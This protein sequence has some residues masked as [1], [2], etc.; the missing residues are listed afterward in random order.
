MSTTNLFDGSAKDG[1]SMSVAST[2]QAASA[3]SLQHQTPSLENLL[4]RSRLTSESTAAANELVEM[5]MKEGEQSVVDIDNEETE[6]GGSSISE[7]MDVEFMNQL[8]NSRDFFGLMDAYSMV[9]GESSDSA[10][11]TE[12]S[13]DIERAALRNYFSS[14]IL[15]ELALAENDMNEE[16]GSN[17]VEEGAT[18][19]A[20][21][22]RNSGASSATSGRSQSGNATG[23]G[24]RSKLGNYAEI[25]RNMMQ[26]MMDTGGGF[27]GEEIDIQLQEEM[28]DEEM[29]DDGNENE[30][31]EDD[32][33]TA[34]TA[35]S[36]LN[37]TV[38][39]SST[40]HSQVESLASAAAALRRQFSSGSS[41][42]GSSSQPGASSSQPS[43]FTTAGSEKMN[44]R[45]IVMN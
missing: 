41:T 28:C 29:T 21:A 37:N 43:G 18:G 34:S 14:A 23:T 19:T 25:I 15:D 36:S 2:N 1:S 11:A 7:M 30:E 13:D 44:W 24:I 38:N 22:N 10:S 40:F 39:S 4:S 9:R 26:Q 33:G 5:V 20:L 32:F 35:N 3:E 8:I 12:N 27:D 42:N 17:A 31:C 16:N 6:D 45:H